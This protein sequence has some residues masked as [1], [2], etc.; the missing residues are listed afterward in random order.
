L[1][2]AREKIETELVQQELKKYLGGV[3]SAAAN[4]RASRFILFELMEGSGIARE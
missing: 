1:N 4:L 2:K 3:N